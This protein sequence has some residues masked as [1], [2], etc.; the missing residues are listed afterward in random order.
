MKDKEAIKKLVDKLDPP[1]F[2]GFPV[3]KEWTYQGLP[4]KV[5]HSFTYCGYV[6]IPK[7]SPIAYLDEDNLNIEV[8][9][10]VTFKAEIGDTV[11]FGWDCAHAGDELFYHGNVVVKGHHWTLDEV[12]EETNK[13]AKQLKRLMRKYA[14][15]K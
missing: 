3:L 12:V 10:G 15:N 9:G 11:W 6:G 2:N 14:R 1:Y 8:H 13:M 4:C 7:E 5:V